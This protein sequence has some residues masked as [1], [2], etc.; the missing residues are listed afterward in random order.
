MGTLPHHFDV[1]QIK[2]KLCSDERIKE[3]FK[4]F[5]KK[6][7]NYVDRIF[8]EMKYISFE[9]NTAICHYLE[10]GDR[11]YFVESGILEIWYPKSR[12]EIL[13]PLLD[14]E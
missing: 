11:V 14:L 4:G 2:Q 5:P 7:E 10:K 3:C 12:S 6:L 1:R 8:D 9:K 13:Q